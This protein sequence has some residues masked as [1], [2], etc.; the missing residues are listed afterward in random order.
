MHVRPPLDMHDLRVTM[1]SGGV[2]SASRKCFL[3][4][5]EK[6]SFLRLYGKI[7]GVGKAEVWSSCPCSTVEWRLLIT[8][9]C[10]NL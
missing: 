9:Q 7:L 3:A 4:N 5:F 10:N 6:C 8:V 1:E 2:S